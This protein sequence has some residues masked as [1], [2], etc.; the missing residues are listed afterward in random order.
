VRTIQREDVESFL[1]D[2]DVNGVKER[3][4]H[5]H[6]LRKRQRVR[7]PVR[8]SYVL[9]HRPK[10][11]W[12]E[13]MRTLRRTA[14]ITLRESVLV[15]RCYL[16]TALRSGQHPKRKRRQKGFPPNH[17]HNHDE[18]FE[19]RATCVYHTVAYCRDDQLMQ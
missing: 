6:Q 8:N 14:C 19:G 4:Q 15:R 16:L 3:V 12:Q 2:V 1:V 10:T 9:T 5:L 7:Q 17:H 18:T 13:E 11:W